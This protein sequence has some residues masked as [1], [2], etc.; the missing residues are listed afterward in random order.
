MTNLRIILILI[1]TMFILAGCNFEGNTDA[2]PT[3]NS[4]VEQPINPLPQATETPS[5]TAT[6]ANTP[7]PGVTLSPTPIPS[8]VVAQAETSTPTELPISGPPELPT[9]VPSSTPSVIEYTIQSGDT[10][11]SIVLSEPFNYTTTTIFTTIIRINDNMFSADVLPPVGEVIRIPLPSPTPTGAPA[12]RNPGTN[13]GGGESNGPT[14][15]DTVNLPD[16]VVIGQHTVEEGETA[17]SI[18]RRFNMT[19]GQLSQVNNEIQFPGCNF[20]LSF[21]G[22]NCAPIIGEG[23]LI[24]VLLPLPTATLTPTPSGNETATPTPTYRAPIVVSPPEGATASGMVNLSWVSVGRLL[25]DEYYLVTVRNMDAGSIW[26]GATRNTTILLPN[27]LIP[28]AEER[29]QIEWEVTVARRSIEG[30]FAPIGAI[31]QVNRFVWN[32]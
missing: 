1:G 15:R 29:H 25:A 13:N 14:T 7:T 18:V 31:G 6:T 30:N 5:P 9:S 26:N 27:D 32:G 23:Q 19:L 2:T 20:E 16:N 8:V 10:L 3:A 11:T 21:G 17:L 22:P 24:N 4:I 28:P 12:T